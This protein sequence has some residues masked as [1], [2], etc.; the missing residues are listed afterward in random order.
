M[1]A[2]SLEHLRDNPFEFLVMGTIGCM[3]GHAF[4]YPIGG[5]ELSGSIGEA[6]KD[7]FNFIVPGS[8]DALKEAF[9]FSVFDGAEA[10][11]ASSAT[12]FET[13]GIEDKPFY[14]FGEPGF[15]ECV[16]NGGTTH[17]H[18]ADLVCHP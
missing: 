14:T 16:T 8:T 5:F 11:L 1:G 13:T 12:G 15:E 2:H 4:M 7:T 10:E 9:S 6:L 3:V 17:P 18:G